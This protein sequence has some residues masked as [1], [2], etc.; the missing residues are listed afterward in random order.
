MPLAAAQQGLLKKPAVGLMPIK[1]TAVRGRMSDLV[2]EELLAAIRDVRLDPGTALSEANVAAQ[3][4]VSRTPVRSAISRLADQGLVIVTAQ[5]GTRV[6]PILLSAVEEACF[7]RGALETA[8]FQKACAG[9]RNVESLRSILVRQEH[10]VAA[11]DADAFFLSDEDLHHEIFVLSGF[12]GVWDV[13]RGPKLHLDRLRRLF[14]P[15]VMTPRALVDEHERIVD[16]LELGD[17]EAGGRLVTQHSRH[18]LNEISKVRSKHP[19]FF[20]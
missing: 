18:V 6:A 15:E 1:R 20:A 12:P 19:D 11:E 7:I 13:L 16:L 3:L 4:C 17:T 9:D 2:Y 14:L 5:V 8:A 10:A